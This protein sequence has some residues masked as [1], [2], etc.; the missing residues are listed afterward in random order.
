[1]VLL[2]IESNN[3]NSVF[4]VGMITFS[5]GCCLPLP[6]FFCCLFVFFRLIGNPLLPDGLF[7]V[8]VAPLVRFLEQRNKPINYV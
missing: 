3:V 5:K 6:R 7:A 4:T 8:A 2:K 1:M